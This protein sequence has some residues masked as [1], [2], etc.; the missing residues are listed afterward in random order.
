M[1]PYV[2][3]HSIPVGPLTLQVWGLFVALGIA[4]GAVVASRAAERNGGDGIVMYDLVTWLIVPAFLFARLLYVVAY[5]PA[6]YVNDPLSVFRV[7]EGGASSFGG[8]IG[9]LIG[10]WAFFRVHRKEALRK[11]AYLE[12]AAYAFP[13]GY[14]IGRLGCFFIHDHPGTLSNAWFAVNYPGGARLDHG[15]LL[16]VTG[17][18]IFLLFAALRRF[19]PSGKPRYLP[20]L[21]V[22]YGAA[23]FT[24]DFWRAR[25]LPL[26]DPRYFGLTPSQYGALLLLAAGLWMGYHVIRKGGTTPSMPPRDDV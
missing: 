1:I 9:A 2:A 17:F 13:L 22:C 21:F 18:A 26:S 12:A 25:D 14:G 20:L 16:A 11:H 8:F 24:L 6:T 15:L 4:L 5:D 19:R 23:R 3:L 10:G 7:W